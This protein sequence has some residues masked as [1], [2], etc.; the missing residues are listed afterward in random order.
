VQSLA[1]ACDALVFIKICKHLV[2]IFNSVINDRYSLVRTALVAILL[3]VP[4]Q[5]IIPLAERLLKDCDQNV[6]HW[7]AFSAGARKWDT[8]NIRDSLIAMLDDSLQEGREEAI[9]TLS[10]LGD[11]RVLPA[12]KTELEKEFKVFR[13]LEAAANL[14]DESL[15]PLLK[16][17]MLSYKNDGDEGE[18]I[19]IKL[20]RR[21]MR[22][23]QK[24]KHKDQR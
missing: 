20:Y 21:L 14:G 24:E 18:L 3:Y 19:A 1:L 8:Q 10:V 13:M 4:S 16:G 12:L 22:K 9:Y 6:R 15:L 7:A 5:K 23:V 2:N 17:I 11:K